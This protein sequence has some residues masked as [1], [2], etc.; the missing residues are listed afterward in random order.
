MNIKIELSSVVMLAYAIVPKEQQTYSCS[1]HAL[2]QHF[3]IGQSL[4]SVVS[5][6]LQLWGSLQMRPVIV[7]LLNAYR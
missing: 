3:S 1:V 5:W 6:R 4:M 7:I 2:A